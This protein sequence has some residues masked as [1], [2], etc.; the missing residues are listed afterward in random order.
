[1]GVR[2]GGGVCVVCVLVCVCGVWVDYRAFFFDFFFDRTFANC[3]NFDT[4]LIFFSFF[5]QMMGDCPNYVLNGLT[6][7]IMGFI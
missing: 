2:V 4:L 6:S 3:T 1:M 5:F 7:Q